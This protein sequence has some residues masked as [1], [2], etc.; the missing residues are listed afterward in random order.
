MSQQGNR[1]DIHRFVEAVKSG[2]R[3]I[4]FI[5]DAENLPAFC[6]YYK[7]ADRIR[8]ALAK[9]ANRWTP[10]RERVEIIIHQGKSGA[11]KT[12]AVYENNDSDQVYPMFSYKP[13]WWD[14]YEDE[15]IVLFDEFVGQIPIARMLRLMDNYPVKLPIKGGTVMNS[16]KKLYFCSNVDWDEWWPDMSDEHKEAFRRR[17]TKVINFN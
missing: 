1:V 6:K 14:G 12:L 5:S 8:C 3:D 7:V 15:E 16:Y 17:V 9:Q 2:K 13:E 4:D 10:E 11:G